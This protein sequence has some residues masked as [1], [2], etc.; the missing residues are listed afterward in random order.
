MVNLV[1]ASFKDEA[2]AKSASQKLSELESIGDITIYETVIVKKNL[3][4][5]TEILTADTTAGF[6]TLS[7]MAVGTLVGAIAGPVGMAV[8]MF[9]GTL[10]G[11]AWESDYFSFSEDFGSKVTNKM[12]PGTFALVAEIDEDNNVFVDGTLAP[13]GGVVVRT[14]VDYEYEKYNDEQVEEMEEE[15]AA[16]RM[17]LRLAA[18][19]EKEKIQNR[20]SKLKQKRAQKITELEK[21][22]KESVATGKSKVQTLGQDIKSSLE[23]LKIS[24]LKS[25]IEKYQEKLA[26]LENKL[27]H[28]VS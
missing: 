24:R 14:D 20:I 9:T 10:G 23:E 21:R 5:Q 22:A 8:G 13:L 3:D 12:S 2:K 6:R 17:R 4:G 7:G 25:K 15:I 1:I 11:I 16:E 27:K 28:M 19:D 18:S 26:A